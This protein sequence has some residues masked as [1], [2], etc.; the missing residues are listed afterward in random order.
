MEK[1]I[2]YAQALNTVLTNPEIEFAQ[3]VREKLEALLA[4][5]SKNKRE[6]GK[7]TAQQIENLETANRL[8]DE[9]EANRTYT[10]GELLKESAVIKAYNESHE[11]E[12]SSQKLAS[13]LGLLIDDKK[14]IKTVE[15][16]KT[17]YSK[18]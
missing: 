15:K 2:T 7:P 10:I 5:V 16:R 8:Y 13:L 4:S 14:L 3:D 6:A 18:A 12:M 9:F 1:K 17:Y 11:K